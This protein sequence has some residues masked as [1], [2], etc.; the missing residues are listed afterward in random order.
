MNGLWGSDYLVPFGGLEEAAH[1][2]GLGAEWM[3]IEALAGGEEKTMAFDEQLAQAYRDNERLE[4]ENTQLRAEKKRIKTAIAEL[5]TTIAHEQ[6]TGLCQG[7]EWVRVIASAK[8]A[9]AGGEE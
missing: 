6:Q 5:L 1:E 3:K 2:G 8:E 7:S 9:L 4:A